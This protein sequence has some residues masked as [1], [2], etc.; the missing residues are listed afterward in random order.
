MP[1]KADLDHIF[2]LGNSPEVMRYISFGRTQTY[3]EARADLRRRI[4]QSQNTFGYWVTEERATKAFV[5]WMSLKPL[6]ETDD[7]EIGYRFLEKHW[8][9][10]YATEAGHRLLQYAFDEQGLDRI[11]AVSL[12]D[13]VASTKVMQ[14]IGLTYDHTGRYYDTEC[15]FYAIDRQ[16]WNALTDA[17]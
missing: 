7:T 9:K 13:N 1:T 14:K 2:Q 12:E 17:D 11:V 4:R 8:N 16:A 10:G 3:S 5:G 6:D 15:V